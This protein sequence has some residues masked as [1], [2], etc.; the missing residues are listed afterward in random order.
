MIM[1]T[2]TQDKPQVLVI[3]VGNAYRRDDAVGLVVARRLREKD[4]KGLT[5]IEESGGR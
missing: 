3:G 2:S 5:V 1:I 4:L